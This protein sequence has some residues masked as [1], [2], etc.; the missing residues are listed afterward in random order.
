MKYPTAH[1][2]IDE[3]KFFLEKMTEY[4]KRAGPRPRSESDLRVT[5]FYASACISAARSVVSVL[6][7]ETGKSPKHRKSPEHKD[8]VLTLT[9]AEAEI[10]ALAK[11]LRDAEVHNIGAELAHGSKLV[12]DDSPRMPAQLASLG[13]SDTS[14]RYVGVLAAQ[15]TTVEGKSV[16]Q[17]LVELCEKYIALVEKL[18]AAWDT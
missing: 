6:R 3:A 13:V 8:W 7:V 5:G 17:D 12:L 16:R 10:A 2:K 14:E 18:V 15:I 11:D 4:A 9:P 1:R